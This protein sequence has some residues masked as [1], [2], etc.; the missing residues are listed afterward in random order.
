MLDWL[1]FRAYFFCLK[2][3]FKTLVSVAASNEMLFLHYFSAVKVS[4][5]Y[6][7]TQ[8]VSLVEWKLLVIPW[9]FLVLL[10]ISFIPSIDLS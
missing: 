9:N 3:I 2:I 4:N 6:M 10:S 5:C 7:Y 8:L 1:A